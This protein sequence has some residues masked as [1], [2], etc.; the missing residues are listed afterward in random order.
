MQRRRIATPIGKAHSKFR[1][2][3]ESISL[4]RWWRWC[5]VCSHPAPDGP[6]GH[7]QG[8]GD[9]PD[10][11][12]VQVTRLIQGG[13]P[14]HGGPTQRTPARIDH[15]HYLSTCWLPANGRAC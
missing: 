10:M 1:V 11:F 8:L 6:L 12:A 13:Q 15:Q 7:A 4:F 3:P 5:P 14:I 9:Q 2:D